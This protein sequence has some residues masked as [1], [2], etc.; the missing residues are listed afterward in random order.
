MQTTD[1]QKAALLRQNDRFARMA[2]AVMSAYL[3]REDSEE[4]Y[5]D[6]LFEISRAIDAYNP[7]LGYSLEAL[8]RRYLSGMLANDGRLLATDKA[9]AIRMSSSTDECGM[10]ELGDPRIGTDITDAA[11]V[12]EMAIRT[13][14]SDR[15]RTALRLLR[16]G[17]TY[18][19]IAAEMDIGYSG[20]RDLCNRAIRAARGRLDTIRTE[21]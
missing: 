16:D 19:E 20:A 7:T 2:C 17:C 8:I 18:A 6:A 4:L 9:E 5:N 21:A 11:M 14:Q 15:Q 10:P 12:L 1:R 13:C 3:S